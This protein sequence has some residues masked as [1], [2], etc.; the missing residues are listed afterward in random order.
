MYQLHE[1]EEK[2]IQRGVDVAT[3]YRKK[4]SYPE[5]SPPANSPQKT[6]TPKISLLGKSLPREKP[7]PKNPS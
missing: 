3:G 4:K 6:P 7:P 1:L 2:Q 5:N